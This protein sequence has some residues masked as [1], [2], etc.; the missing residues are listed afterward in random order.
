[1][2]ALLPY[3]CRKKTKE[4]VLHPSR[5]S[6]SMLHPEYAN[7][8]PTADAA[9]IQ[10]GFPLNRNASRLVFT[11]RKSL[12]VARLHYASYNLCNN[13]IASHI[14]GR[15][16]EW[17]EDDVERRLRCWASFRKVIIHCIN[18]VTSKRIHCIF[19]DLS[20]EYFM[21]ESLKTNLF[22]A[23]TQVNSTSAGRWQEARIKRKKWT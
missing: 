22:P 12:P 5:A 2:G 20:C 4:T 6:I 23:M 18:W 16:R 15:P 17:N 14:D 10:T 8:S 11:V 21:N 7:R 13:Q 1:M 9:E 3:A 19:S